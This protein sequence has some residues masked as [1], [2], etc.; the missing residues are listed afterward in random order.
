[1]DDQLN[2]RDELFVAQ[3]SNSSPG[4]S[5]GAVDTATVEITDDDGN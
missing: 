1:V 2:E 5:I 3:L 4:A